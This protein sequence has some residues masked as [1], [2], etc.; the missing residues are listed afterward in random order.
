MIKNPVIPAL[1]ALLLV[2][3]SALAET[4]LLWGD[5]HLH[6]A[7]SPDAF[8]AGN[9]TA[10]PDVAYRYAKGEP[11]IHP[12]AGNRVQINEPLDFLAVADH[13]EYLGIFPEVMSG[14][15][16]QPEADLF[17]KIKSFFYVEL[18]RYFIADP[19]KGTE[20]FRGMMATTDIQ[21]GDTRDP[22]ATAN[23]AGNGIGL[24]DIGLINDEAAARISA[25]QWTRSMEVADHYYQPGKFTTLVGWEWSQTASGANLHRVVLSDTDGKTAS[26][27]S[28]IGADD[29]PYP[30][31]LW[32]QLATLSASVDANFISIPHNS[33][34]SKGYMF[35]KTTVAGEP[36]TA[37]YA[38]KRSRWEPLVEATQIKGDSET[39]PDL[40]PDDEFADFERYSFYIQGIS[41]GQV[42]KV[43][44]GDTVRS[45][46]KNGIEL[47]KDTG[48][49][50]FKLGMIGSTDAHTSLASAEEPNFWGKMSTDSIPRNKRGDDPDGYANGKTST[51]GWTMSA[52]GLAAVWSDDNSREAIIAAMKRRET[53]ATTGPRIGVRFFGG[54]D[55]KEEDAQA[56]DMAAVGY[57]GGVPMGGELARAPAG[58]APRF[59]MA[60][61]K[62]ALD[63][64]LDRIQVVKLWLNSDGQAEEKIFNV[65]WSGSTS[66]ERALQADGK[67]PAVGNS[68]DTTT[69]KTENSIGAPQLS[70]LWIDP[71]F[72]AEQTALYYLRVLQIPTVRHSQLDAIALGIETPFEGPATIQERAYTSPIW[73]SPEPE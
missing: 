20:T 68:A 41:E 24:S 18:I 16:E 44:K 33:N 12:Y 30:E 63:H 59:L 35:A 14:R 50:P 15:A 4:Q 19:R 21:P 43:Q 9:R 67:L 32:D 38:S 23:E 8:M 10:G 57:A 71:E 64:N 6:T 11:V 37:D 25:S 2:S 45:A 55:Y 70:A 40:A 48:V 72:D 52:S 34:I 26:T 60:A 51:N 28:P 27:F 42:Y 58:A 65:A 54:W 69:G 17:E 22:I 31:Q 39:H 7:N 47:E 5:T 13:A 36:I 62:G 49:N 29:A 46:L 53:Y 61:S 56:A 1:S 73:Y 66:G 3:S